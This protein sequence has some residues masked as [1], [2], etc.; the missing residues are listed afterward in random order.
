[1]SANNKKASF[2]EN[3][4]AGV[5]LFVLIACGLAW[6]KGGAQGGEK[7][8]TARGLNVGEKVE[9]SAESWAFS[10]ENALKKAARLAKKDAHAAE[11]FF[12][13]EV[14]EGRAFYVMPGMDCTVLDFSI[15]GG[16]VHV[17]TSTGRRGW[18]A[19]GV[20]SRK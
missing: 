20:C 15:L 3:L 7:G 2:S 17:Q 11:V 10:D 16:T 18:I 9:I 14:R 12:K 5:V 4:I 6:C 19:E 1:M 8:E 13:A